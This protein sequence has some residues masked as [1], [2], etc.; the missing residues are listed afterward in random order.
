MPKVKTQTNNVNVR[1]SDH[2]MICLNEI[3]TK[4]GMSRTEYLRFLIHTAIE[5]E[6][7]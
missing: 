3:S 4:K 7:V 2:V 6:L 1:L 5:K